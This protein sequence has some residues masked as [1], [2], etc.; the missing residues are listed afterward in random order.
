MVACR[1]IEGSIPPPPVPVCRSTRGPG[2]PVNVPSQNVPVLEQDTMEATIEPLQAHRDE[3]GWVSEVYSGGLGETLR[4]IHL[5][6]L[7]EG[8]VRGNHV[9]PNS[10]EWIVFLDTPVVVALGPAEDPDR[11]RLTQ[12]SRVHLPAGVPH[13]FHNPGPDTVHFVAYRDTRYD[14]QDPDVEPRDLLEPSP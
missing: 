14:E 11:R 1:L 6:T 9:H 13:A 5:G 7:R 4:N 2:N 12:P 10:R 8:F 3:R